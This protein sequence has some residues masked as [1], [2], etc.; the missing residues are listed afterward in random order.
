M[1]VE[2]LALG[3]DSYFKPVPKLVDIS[4]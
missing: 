2:F 4:N 1:V 3:V